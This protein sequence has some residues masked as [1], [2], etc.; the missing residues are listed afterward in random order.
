M[1]LVE[2]WVEETYCGWIGDA[3]WTVG[4]AQTSMKESVEL[5]LA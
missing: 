5:R 1:A 2:L 3:H 4:G